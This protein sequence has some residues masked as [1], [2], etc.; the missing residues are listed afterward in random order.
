M[1][2]LLWS[3]SCCYCQHL[4][5]R[6]AY[7][8]AIASGIPAHIQTGDLWE[9]IEVKTL[10]ALLR[11]VVHPSAAGE[12]VRRRLVGSSSPEVKVPLTAGL[13]GWVG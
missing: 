4:Q 11:S 6:S 3:C 13:G 2:L 8:A 9:S 1:S 5:L 12:G 7:R 10:L